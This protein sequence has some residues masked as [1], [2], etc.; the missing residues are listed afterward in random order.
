MQ[1]NEHALEPSRPALHAAM[2]FG[3]VE[4][5]ADVSEGQTVL[6]R[7][8]RTCSA[9]NRTCSALASEGILPHG[10]SPFHLNVPSVN[11]LSSTTS[12]NGLGVPT[13]ATRLI[14]LHQQR[15]PDLLGKT[16]LAR[17]KT[18]RAQQ[19]HSTHNCIQWPRH[20]TVRPCLPSPLNCHALFSSL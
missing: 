13:R 18:G 14:L 16:G 1:T 12:T 17:R 3:G 4:R 20:R 19:P 9:L 10:Q 7:R 11:I 8:N 2:L 15:K 5:K 6:A